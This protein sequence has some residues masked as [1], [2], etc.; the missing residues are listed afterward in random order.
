MLRAKSAT[1]VVAIA[2]AVE[3]AIA[4]FRG[5]IAGGCEYD[6]SA[7]PNAQIAEMQISRMV[8]VY[9]LQVLPKVEPESVQRELTADVGGGFVLSGHWD[10]RE[11]SGRLRDTKTGQDVYPAGPQFGGY[12][13]LGLA[14]GLPGTAAGGDYIERV[15]LK[16]PQPAAVEIE[17][18]VGQCIKEA[19]RTIKRIKQQVN[20]WRQTKDIESISSNPYSQFCTNRMCPARN[21]DF[22]RSW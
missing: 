18:D 6:K 11:V 13:L 21:T 22:C 12:A 17:Y 2:E 5:G 9:A 14:H 15:S 7:T 20:E 1:Y 19:A 8:E 10:V 4:E 3:H 16:K